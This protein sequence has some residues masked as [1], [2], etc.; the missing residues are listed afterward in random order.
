M[1]APTPDPVEA[2][3][4]RLAARALK[5]LDGDLTGHSTFSS[6]SSVAGSCYRKR[7]TFDEFTAV[8]W[9]SDLG[10]QYAD[11]NGLKTRGQ[12]D[13][14][15][16]NAWDWVDEKGFDH[17][18]D[19]RIVRER[20][21]VLASRVQKAQWKGR[22]GS[23]ERAVALALIGLGHELNKFTVDAD[24]LLLAEAAG[25]GRATV[26][27]A[28]ARLAKKGFVTITWH[29][30]EGD[31]K[32]NTYLLNL[33]WV[34][35]GSFINGTHSDLKPP[36]T[37]CVSFMKLDFHPVFARKAL[38]ASA[39]RIW[40]FLLEQQE[41]ATQRQVRESTGLS[42]GAV[43]KHLARMVQFGLVQSHPGHP[44]GY[45]LDPAGDLWA[46][47]EAHG[48][49]DWV[50]QTAEKHKRQREG[51]LEV[52]K[53]RAAGITQ[54]SR[55]TGTAAQRRAR[56]ILT[57]IPPTPRTPVGSPEPP[58]DWALAPVPALE[59][60][61]LIEDWFTE[62]EDEWQVLGSDPFEGVPTDVEAA[63]A[64]VIYGVTR[65][66]VPPVT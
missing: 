9:H 7:F 64:G 15:V 61:G 36:N 12:F 39:R 18:Y 56:E 6:V 58:P 60:S 2:L 50:E 22:G 34:D 47:A 54:P 52:K 59:D 16:R 57:V 48:T 66:W 40:E 62:L 14:N 24:G 20:L 19:A 53:Q 44:A 37:Q 25:V 41:P 31:V 35:Q 27:R 65:K 28:A 4:K 21:A 3:R 42:A 26:H 49:Q 38:G 13:K 45:S 8:L 51:W 33:D 30:R 17:G 23:S 55:K 46:V 1:T 10:A 43:S 5:V 32:A 11:E 29:P 63:A